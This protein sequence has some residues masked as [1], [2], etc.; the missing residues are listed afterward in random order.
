MHK[1]G[2]LILLHS[3]YLYG[4]YYS[5]MEERLQKIVAAAHGISRR[6]AEEYIIDGRVVVNGSVAE[7][8][9]KAD[10]S[11]DSIVVDGKKISAKRA[12]GVV[13]QE[14]W[15]LN[16]P[17][18]VV[19]S[20]FDP[21][22]ANTV[23]NF[24]PK[25]LLKRNWFFVGRL[26]KDSEGMLLLTNDGDFANNVAHPSFNVSKKYRVTL[27]KPFNKPDVPQMLSGIKNDGELLYFKNLKIVNSRKIDVILSQ[28]KNREIRRI[29]NHFGYEVLKLKRVQIGK[30]QLPKNMAP[31][32]IKLL[33]QREIGTIFA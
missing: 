28:G 18:G 23:V 24:V 17:V 12:A 29:M 10:A 31:G 27:D 13:A 16:K 22:N 8:G 30:L 32:Q 5:F 11:V 2:F 6:A 9:S 25:S 26:D 19:C 1:K 14:V 33:T 20:H 21:N 7:I 15:L 4:V 3:V